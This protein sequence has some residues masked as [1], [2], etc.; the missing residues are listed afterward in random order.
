M[1]KR[2]DP[3][4][5]LKLLDIVEWNN[6]AWKDDFVSWCGWFTTDRMKASTDYKLMLTSSFQY[7]SL[8]HLVDS[9]ALPPD[10]AQ[11][12]YLVCQ[13]HSPVSPFN[14]QAC[15]ESHLKLGNLWLYLIFWLFSY[16]K[17]WAFFTLPVSLCLSDFAFFFYFFINT[18]KLK[19][20]ILHSSPTPVTQC[21]KFGQTHHR[22]FNNIVYPSNRRSFF[23]L[24]KIWWNSTFLF[25]FLFSSF[26]TFLTSPLSFV[27]IF[28]VL[29]LFSLFLF[30]FTLHLT[31]S[32][33]TCSLSF[34]Q[35]VYIYIYIYIRCFE[36]VST[37]TL[38]SYQY[39]HFSTPA[40]FARF[41]SL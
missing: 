24:Y 4:Y 5:Y 7:F 6:E 8:M 38:L 29:Q 27:F 9:D 33:K 21:I 30:L 19:K 32:Q 12:G 22:I 2:L 20:N 16:H 18:M 39:D 31:Y 36:Y 40:L 41:S 23:F 13:L 26:S 37:L 28:N 34:S 14:S 11:L 3:S 10:K 17:H 1:I 25:L 15:T 35:C